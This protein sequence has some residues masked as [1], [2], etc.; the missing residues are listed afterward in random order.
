MGKNKSES[1]NMI[2]IIIVVVVAALIIA[3]GYIFWQNMTQSKSATSDVKNSSTRRKSVAP[4]K[5]D[6]SNS[7]KDFI[8]KIHN[9]TN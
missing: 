4:T 3:L 6:G 2:S 9:N 8:N 1:G 5:E 7:N